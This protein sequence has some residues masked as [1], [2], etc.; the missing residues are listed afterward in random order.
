[1]FGQMMLETCA[2]VIMILGAFRSSSWVKFNAFLAITFLAF[3]ARSGHKISKHVQTASTR[4]RA[5]SLIAALF[6]ALRWRF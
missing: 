6:S 4:W 3:S 5:A 1:M 2:G